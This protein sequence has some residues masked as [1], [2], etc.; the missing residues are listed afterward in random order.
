MKFIFLAV[1]FILSGAQAG[2]AQL[3][4]SSPRDILYTIKEHSKAIKTSQI[5]EYPVHSAGP[6]VMGGR[7]TDVA[8]NPKNHFEFYVAYASG[9][10][11]RT[12]NN[13][14][15]FEPI[16]DNEGSL[17]IGD[18]S[19]S[20]AD[21]NIIW[22]GT[23][24]NN[25]SRSSYAG[26]GIYKS[27]DG[28]K[29]WIYSGLTGTQ[30][31]GRIVT[32]PTNP[33]I[34]WV[35]SIGALYSHN[36]DRGVYKTT[37]GGKTWKKTLFINDST[38]VIDLTIN[39]KNPDEL[40]AAS[41][42]RTR[43]AW[44][45]SGSGTGSA[46]Y[47][48]T[49]G[50]ETW[51]KSVHGFPIGEGTG[52]IGLSVSQSSPNIIYAVL[53]NQ[54][55]QTPKKKTK[56]KKPIPEKG[57]KPESFKSMSRKN[58]FALSDSSL[59]TFLH[60][61]DFPDRYN[62]RTV[63]QE[64][65][66][67]K[68]DP[69]ALYDYNHSNADKDLVNT[70]IYGTEVYRSDDSGKH[71]RKMNEHILDGVYYTYGYYFGQIRVN[72]VNP[73]ELYIFGVPF[74]K[75]TDGGRTFKLAANDDV[76]SDFHAL[77]IDP[78]DSNHLIAGC[79]GGVYM[80]YD[81]GSHWTHLNNTAVG[82]FYSINVDNEK[83]FNLYGG[84]QDNGVF[85]GP[86]NSKPNESP[87]WKRLLGGMECMLQSTVLMIIRY[88]LASSLGIIIE[89]TGRIRNTKTSNRCTTLE[90]RYTG[91]TGILRLSLALTTRM[92]STWELKNC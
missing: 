4:A 89:S 21:P 15:S 44:N 26:V 23:G 57:L 9:G 53:D 67:G 78:A 43:H 27:I 83:P 46:I 52:R 81:S 16:F 7:V 77:W 8:V 38:G 70:N 22:V 90:N 80:S 75:S 42:Q 13:G 1:F 49:D 68:Y 74:I 40:W 6:V 79:D 39:P 92:S 17:A 32:H 12:T 91:L 65:R 64:V 11:F 41:W 48:S 72:P 20:K 30:H 50:G 54:N 51:T 14:Q 35:A 59:N 3:S 29:T 86:Y 25:S 61:N 82:Q 2:L 73:D 55:K 47:R 71:W 33:N 76:H 5:N 69:E 60:N 84:L 18:I 63:K 62:A 37:D 66:A 56:K 45:F 10:V 58:F 31:I 19:V 24:E 34:A 36:Q 28:G 85:Y 88:T 87:H